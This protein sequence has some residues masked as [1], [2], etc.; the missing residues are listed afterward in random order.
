M[1]TLDD[2]HPMNALSIVEKVQILD[3]TA[4]GIILT[5]DTKE[6]N[7]NFYTVLK[8]WPKTTVVK[9]GDTICIGQFSG[10]SFSIAGKEYKI[11]AEHQILGKF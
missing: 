6:V 3:A 10:D 9:P 8:V 11:V 7:L 5:D 4:S 2:I 1:P